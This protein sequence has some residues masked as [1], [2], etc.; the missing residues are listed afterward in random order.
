M[1][2]EQLLFDL[3]DRVRSRFYGK[4]RGTV[5]QV[6]ADTWRLKAMVPAVLGDQECGW[7][8]ACVPYAG[9]QVGMAFLPEAGAGVWI[10]F[11]GGDPS[12]PIWSGC[13]WRAG[14]LPP[15]AKATV[16][17]LVTPGGF[18]WTIDDDQAQ[19]VLRDGHE[20]TVTL[21]ADGIVLE[22]GGQKITIAAGTVSINDGA[23]EVQ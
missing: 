19:V 20:N 21:R 10:E 17:C 5:T 15:A 16:K 13:Y 12:Y 11:E 7:A 8:M 9:P 4:Y 18:Q 22:R 2:E 6:Q 1:N 23:L 14:E 3:A